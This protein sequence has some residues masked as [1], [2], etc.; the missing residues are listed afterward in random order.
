[1]DVMENIDLELSDS[2]FLS[3]ARQAHDLDITFNQLVN[4]I[5]AEAMGIDPAHSRFQHT[6]EQIMATS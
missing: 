6:V 4:N 2:E 1:M 3:L 5:L